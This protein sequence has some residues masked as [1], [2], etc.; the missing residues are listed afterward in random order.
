MIWKQA[1][2]SLS[3]SLGAVLHGRMTSMDTIFHCWT[4]KGSCCTTAITNQLPRYGL[5][6]VSLVKA[7]LC[8]LWLKNLFRS[9]EMRKGHTWT[10]GET[11]PQQF[12]LSACWFWS[13]NIDKLYWL[14]GYKREVDRMKSRLPGL[15]VKVWSMHGLWVSIGDAILT[16]GLTLKQWTTA[17]LLLLQLLLTALGGEANCWG[18]SCVQNAAVCANIFKCITAT[19]SCVLFNCF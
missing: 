5:G 12:T 4:Q 15:S 9:E 14:P 19:D 3:G 6:V 10:A 1:N 11:F 2:G 8:S 17:K 18:K 16:H 7:L 13:L